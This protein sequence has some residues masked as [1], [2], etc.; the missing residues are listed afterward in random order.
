MELK[1]L[2]SRALLVSY[3]EAVLLVS[4]AVSDA[5]EHDALDV[6]GWRRR[7]AGM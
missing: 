1:D 6:N 2:N 7:T 4:S 5:P 3:L